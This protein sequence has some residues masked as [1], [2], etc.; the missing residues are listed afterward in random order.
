MS[1][2]I[3]GFWPALPALILL[4]LFFL[5]PVVRMLGFSIEAGTLDWYAKALSEGLYLQV[6]WNTFEIALLVTAICLLLGYPL[7]FLIATTTPGWATLGFIFVLLPLWTS[8]LVR[9]YAWM[10]LLGRNGVFNRWLIETGVISDPLPLLHNFN[11]VLIGMV[12]VLL[13]YMVLPIYGAVRRLDPALV[14]AAEGLGASNWRIFWR[15]YLPLTLPGIFAGA[16]IVFVLSLGFYITP[17][18]LGGGKVMMV[19]VMIEQEVRQTLNWPFAAALSA[20]LL[21]LTLGVYSV[22]QSFTGR[23]AQ[24]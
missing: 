23:E 9:T 3:R 6:F 10:V 22:A 12:H 21:A 4:F 5:F 14:A 18:L 19:A 24:R 20:V 1:G 2:Q 17:A 16:V 11:G 7:G 8:V 13:P 15:I